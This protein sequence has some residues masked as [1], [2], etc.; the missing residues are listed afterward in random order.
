M[1]YILIFKH[2][3]SGDNAYLYDMAGYIVFVTVTPLCLHPH[4][5]TS[6]HFLTRKINTSYHISIFIIF[7]FI[8]AFVIYRPAKKMCRASAK[9]L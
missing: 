5:F 8:T 2:D 7:L 1:S 9:I 6:Y 3:M 4:K